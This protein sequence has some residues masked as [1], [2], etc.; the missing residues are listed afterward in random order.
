MHRE[1]WKDVLGGAQALVLLTFGDALRW[2]S[3]A[4]DG[5]GGRLAGMYGTVSGP[6]HEIV[7]ARN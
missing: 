1:A 5:D 2:S 7:L 6:S 3:L 4:E